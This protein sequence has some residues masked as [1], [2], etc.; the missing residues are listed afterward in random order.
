[1]I[2]FQA[3]LRNSLIYIEI[4]CAIIAIIKF[5][6]LCNSYWKWFV[7]YLIIIPFAEFIGK[8]ITKN[9]TISNTHYFDYFVIPFEFIF[10]FWL[11]CQSLLKPKLFYIL[12]AVY[13][14]SFLPHLFY[15]NK[16]L[17]VNSLSY[18]IGNFII[19]FLVF[20]E[21]GKQLQT[22]DILNFRQNRMFY[23]NFGVMFFYVGTLPLF[24]F[25]EYLAQNLPVMLSYYYTYFLLANCTMYLLFITSF[26]C[27]KQNS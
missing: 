25:Y 6:T 2:E 8:Y 3:F 18:T 15:D 17:A 10:F 23:I 7:F 26:I 4:L 11:Y 27:G 1:M 14:V 19:L 24:A 5:R 22:D 12:T 20:L 13:L 21:F 9:F 16:I